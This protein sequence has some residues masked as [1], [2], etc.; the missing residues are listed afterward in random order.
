MR[1]A[2]LKAGANRRSCSIY[3]LQ[4]KMINGKVRLTRGNEILFGQLILLTPTGIRN[5]GKASCSNLILFNSL[6][7]CPRSRSFFLANQ[8]T[9][10]LPTRG[11]G[12]GSPAPCI[13]LCFA[14]EAPEAAPQGDPSPT[15]YL[16]FS[17][18][19][20]SLLNS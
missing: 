15:N 20:F 11:C 14:G 8:L 1:I 9:G 18:S 17:F 2:D 7:W 19:T 3:N 5:K 4:S 12:C 16:F 13:T 10:G 6:P